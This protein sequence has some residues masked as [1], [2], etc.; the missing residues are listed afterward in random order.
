MNYLFYGKDSGRIQKEIAKVIAQYGDDCDHIVY[1]LNTSKM[2]DVMS[3]LTTSPFFHAH[4]VVI[5][6]H[7]NFLANGSS[8]FDVSQ[9]EAFLK[10]PLLENTLIM[11]HE[12]EKC[13][14][15]K[16]IVRLINQTCRVKSFQN[17]EERD[18]KGYIAER[19]REL[20]INIAHE[21]LSRL[22][23]RLSCDTA[24]IDLQLEKLA[25]YPLEITAEV[26]DALISRELE[27]NV[28]Q[29]SEA[30]LKGKFKKA[31]QVYKDMVSLSNDPIYLLAVVVSQ[32]RFYYQVKVCMM[33]GMG[34]ERT[35]S[36]LKAHP[37]R[38]KLTMQ[39]VAGIEADTIMKLLDAALTCDLD[40]KN[41]RRDKYFAFEMF[42]IQCQEEI[43]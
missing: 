39:I 29:L 14:S 4:K 25:C 37:Y 18:K 10:D 19:C 24:M 42:M 28:F 13:D 23:E 38:V 3:E 11:T 34:E 1:D 35:A 40:I 8:D 21:A 33:Q 30:L 43:I 9:L 20:D 41:G 12:F 5:V 31:Y 16:K 2:G 32:L 36:Y 6:K 7:C 17:L 27:D 22:A 15:R 26:V